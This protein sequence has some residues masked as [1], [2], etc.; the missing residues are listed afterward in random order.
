[1]MGVPSARFQQGDVFIDYDFEE[2]MFRYDAAT[3]RVF[4]KFYGEAAENEIPHDNG[5]LN[6]AICG[7]EETDAKAYETGKAR[8]RG[9]NGSV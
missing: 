2:V 6:E 1:M 9:L 4:R 3:Q 5:L 7:G 8:T